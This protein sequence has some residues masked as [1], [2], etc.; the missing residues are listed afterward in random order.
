MRF[1]MTFKNCYVPTTDEM[2]TDISWRVIT[3]KSH[4]EKQ[5]NVLFNSPREGYDYE[6]DKANNE[7][8]LR[9][10]KQLYFDV[11]NANSLPFFGTITFDPEKNDRYNTWALH[12]SV[13]NHIRKVT[14][15][16]KY[17]R[18]V[19][20]C[21]RHKDG[22]IH[23]HYLS[24]VETFH[25]IFSKYYGRCDLQ[26][27]LGFASY[28]CAKYLSKGAKRVM[29]KYFYAFNCKRPTKRT[30]KLSAYDWAKILTART[31]GEVFARVL[32]SKKRIVYSDISTIYGRVV[33]RVSACLYGHYCPNR[34]S[35]TEQL[36]FFENT[37]YKKFEKIM[38]K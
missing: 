27:S 6:T 30:M 14:R 32:T 22:A 15:I 23:Y 7:R 26:R 34:D 35:V 12:I 29:H 24:N 19:L 17:A 8:S 2:Q 5:Y 13:L 38:K 18:I 9:R 3:P 10:S 37:L 25:K 33:L 20:V 1:T 11:V 16:D 4:E 28:Y 36:N 31:G 21:E